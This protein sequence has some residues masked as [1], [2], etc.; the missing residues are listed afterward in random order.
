MYMVSL[1]HAYNVFLKIFFVLLTWF[2][3]I[4]IFRV[5]LLHGNCHTSR[6]DL[7]RLSQMIPAGEKQ[8]SRIMWIGVFTPENVLRCYQTHTEIAQVLF[9]NFAL[10][11][12]VFVEV[13]L[14][15][16]C[17]VTNDASNSDL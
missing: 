14:L 11:I 9:S 2:S 10:H 3:G 7:S 6:Y 17:V 5:R 13:E 4:T 8:A 16:F 15:I 12:A 1:S